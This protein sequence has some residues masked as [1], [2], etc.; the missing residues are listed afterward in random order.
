MKLRLSKDGLSRD[1]SIIPYSVIEISKRDPKLLSLVN[2]EFYP[3]TKDLESKQKVVAEGKAQAKLDGSVYKP[4][5]KMPVR[6]GYAGTVGRG[7][8]YSEFSPDLSQFLIEYYSEVGEQVYDPMHGRGTRLMLA[9]RMGRNAVGTDVCWEFHELVKRNLKSMK[10]LDKETMGLP[11]SYLC[12]ARN[13]PFLFDGSVDMILC[14]P[15]YFNIET[16]PSAKNASEGRFR[17]NRCSVEQDCVITNNLG[18]ARC[19]LCRENDK[20]EELGETRRQLTR[21]N[22]QLTDTDSYT[23]F[24]DEMEK[25]LKENVRVLKGSQGDEYHFAVYVVNDFV[26]DGAF[27]PF[28]IDFFIRAVRA[29]FYPWT[30]FVHKTRAVQLLSRVWVAKQLRRNAKQH[31]YILVFIKKTG[32]LEHEKQGVAYTDYSD[33]EED[34]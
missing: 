5:D 16:Y 11:E 6:K 17:C 14:C 10:S 25:I 29:G 19:W 22:E 34:E 9:H 31:E 8:R 26:Q 28:H 27:H 3:E 33:S 24:L 18:D 12:D 30:M 4:G 13:V 7:T 21:G 2:D 23:D 1:F 20:M 15:P 32:T